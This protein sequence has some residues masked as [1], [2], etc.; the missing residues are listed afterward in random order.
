[1]P[2]CIQ[3]KVVAQSGRQY[4]LSLCK[5]AK[6]VNELK[7]IDYRRFKH[8]NLEKQNKIHLRC[9]SDVHGL[10]T[11][12]ITEDIFFFL[13]MSPINVSRKQANA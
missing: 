7:F 2:T 9:V 4:L 5:N 8:V 3:W 12:C 1:M 11:F 6:H 10:S 13:I